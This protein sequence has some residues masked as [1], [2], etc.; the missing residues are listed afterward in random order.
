[1]SCLIIFKLE[2]DNGQCLSSLSLKTGNLKNLCIVKQLILNAA[3]PV[4]AS[5]ATIQPSSSF[6]LF[7][8]DAYKNLSLRQIVSIK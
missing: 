5:T 4:G 8:L 7:K 2:S 3:I 6:L 1:M